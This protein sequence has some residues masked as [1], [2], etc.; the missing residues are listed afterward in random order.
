MSKCTLFIVMVVGFGTP[1]MAQ[2]L[3]LR[4]AQPPLMN[5]GEPDQ[6]QRLAA[7]SMMYVPPPEP[8]GYEMHDQVMIVIDEVSRQESEQTFE[9]E[10]TFDV[11]ARLNTI[12]DPMELLQMR[13][14]TGDTRNLTFADMG[15]EREYSGEGVSERSDRIQDRIKAEII[16]VKPNGVIVLEAK[17]TR[18][19]NGE[20]QLFVLS[21]SCHSD[22]VTAEGVV[23]SSLLANLMLVI[24]NEGDIDRAARKGWITKT[25]DRVFA[26]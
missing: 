15:F 3:W 14:R 25:L 19:V 24:E 18:I 1:A 17:R 8:R 20:T 10:K 16:D 23:Q 22:D 7:Y 5:A 2:S 13:L 11:N 12:I 26:F 21:G 4:Q 6:G 9:S